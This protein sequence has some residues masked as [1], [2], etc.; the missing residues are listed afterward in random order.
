L[1][2]VAQRAALWSALAVAAIGAVTFGYF[3][4]EAIGANRPQPPA[5]PV[6]AAASAPVATPT[7]TP[8]GK[9]PL[10][11]HGTGDV[12]LDPR[13]LGSALSSFAAPWDG[14]RALFTEDDLSIVN[15]ECAPS[16]LGTPQDKEYNFRCDKGHEAMRDA[17]VDVANMGNNHSGDFGQEAL[18]DGRARLKRAGVEPVGAGRDDAEANAP[19]IF[20]L[21]GWRIAVLGFGGVVPARSWISGPGHPGVADGYDTASMVRAVQAADAQADLVFVAIHWGEELDTKPRP[22]D[23]YRAHTLIDAGADAIFGHH[24]HRLQQLEFYKGRPI[25]YGLGNF[26]WPSGGP[27]A[28]AQV[29]ISPNGNVNA[30]LLPA[31]IGA[32]RPTLTGRTTCTA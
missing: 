19:A 1:S 18:L 13:Q 25:A 31:R 6:A 29:V 32:G 23:V 27:T 8:A 10:I 17:G 7:P 28:V 4:M 24:A 21:K 2:P 11:V 14:V 3:G 22:D 16:P 30:C 5:R 20:R 15:L 26:V 12:N 9:Q